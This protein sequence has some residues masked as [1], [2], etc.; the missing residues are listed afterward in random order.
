MHG[1]EEGAANSITF[2]TMVALRRLQGAARLK[3]EPRPTTG[4]QADRDKQPT[5]QE[6]E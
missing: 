2:E 5:N 6:E 1:E 4:E 3:F